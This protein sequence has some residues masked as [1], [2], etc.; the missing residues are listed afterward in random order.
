MCCSVELL[1]RPAKGAPQTFVVFEFIGSGF[2]AQG[3]ALSLNSKS[4]G[5]AAEKALEE[6]ASK[7]AMEAEQ[8][9]FLQCSKSCLVS[10]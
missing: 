9:V 1:W 7:A 3:P 5:K 8:V 2:R 4:H 6:K 10:G